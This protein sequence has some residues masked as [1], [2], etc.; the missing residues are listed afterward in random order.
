MGR[1]IQTAYGQP[2]QVVL[3]LPLLT[4]LDGERK[5]SKSYGNAIGITEPPAE[6]YG[7]TLASGTLS[8]TS[9]T[10]CCW[11]RRRRP[12]SARATPSGPSR[13]RS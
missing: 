2:P 11:A 8:S 1:A 6:I 7:K 9:G 4:G 3:T 5:M 13:A 10:R 12:G